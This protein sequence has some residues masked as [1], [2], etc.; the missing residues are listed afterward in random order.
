MACTAPGSDRP[1]AAGQAERS[2]HRNRLHGPALAAVHPGRCRWPAAG[3]AMGQRAGLP[4]ARFR[5]G[6]CCAWRPAATRRPSCTARMSKSKAT[7]AVLMSLAEVLQDLELDWEYEVSRWL[8][9]VG[10]T[11]L[12]QRARCA[13]VS[14]AYQ[15]VRQP[16]TR[17]SPNTSAKNRAPWSARPK[18]KR[19]FASST[20]SSSTSTDSRPASS[21][22]P[23]P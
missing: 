20:A 15:S 22:H 3:N 11:L 17:T 18:L 13:A 21:A 6:A 8:G 7:A 1:S 5:H 23:L 4:L 2:N 16:A 14:A 19:A 10:A 12:D 9:P